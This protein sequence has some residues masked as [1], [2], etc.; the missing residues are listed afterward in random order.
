MTRLMLRKCA[1]LVIVLVAVTFFVSALLR[2]TPNDSV[3]RIYPTATEE[4]KAAIRSDLG[5]DRPVIS[6]Y[7][8]WLTNAVRGDLGRSLTAERLSVGEQIR[9]ALPPTL[10]LVFLAQFLALLVAIPL[11]VWSASRANG[12]FDKTAS[13]SSFALLAIPNY[14]LGLVLAYVVG[15]RL[16]WLPT[17]GYVPI[18]DGPWDWLRY[19]ILPT[20]TLA[21]AQIAIYQRLLRSDMITTLHSDFITTARAKGLSRARILWRHALRPSS[22]SLLTI[23]AINLGA[24]IGGAVV[25]E[26]IFQLPGMGKLIA[27]AIF[28]NDYVTVQGCVAVIAIGYVLLNFVVDISYALLDPRT[29]RVTTAA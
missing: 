24:L 8:D 18:G 29:R 1:Q 17:Q 20:V 13:I 12:V 15:V 25:I 3:D 9:N 10:Q 16:Q 4:Q 28:K 6:Q 5:I 22:I 11:G 21:A 7:W 14:V 26:V 27:D 23:A 2:L 19:M